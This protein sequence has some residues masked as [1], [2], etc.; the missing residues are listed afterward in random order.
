MHNSII[1]RDGLTDAGVPYDFGSADMLG[2]HNVISDWHS[3]E[4]EYVD[5]N[6]NQPLSRKNS[7]ILT[8]PNFANP[9]ENVANAN[10]WLRDMHPRASVRVVS[11]GNR[12]KY[13]ETVPF[14]ADTSS[15]VT[16]SMMVNGEKRKSIVQTV[17]RTLKKRPDSSD[18]EATTKWTK[19]WNDEEKDL[20]HEPRFTGLGLERGPYEVMAAIQRVLYVNSNLFDRASASGANWTNA[21]G[22]GQLQDAIDAAGVYSATNGN[23]RAY[24]FA[25]GNGLSLEPAVEVRDG[26]TVF[27]SVVDTYDEV[28][29]PTPVSDGREFLFKEK[30]IFNYINRVRASRSGVASS[31]QSATSLLSG[32][33]AVVDDNE[34]KQTKGFVLDGFHITNNA[35]Q[36]TE[37]PLL[38]HNDLTLLRNC[39]VRNNR[40]DE[41]VKS[42][43]PVVDIKGGLLYN[44]LV[45]DND[46]QT[47][48]N[49]V[50]E[51]TG[52]VLNCTVVANGADQIAI[53]TAT[54]GKVVNAITYNERNTTFLSRLPETPDNPAYPDYVN[55]NMHTNMFAPYLRNGANAYNYPFGTQQ[56][57][58]YQLH[59]QSQSIDGG[60]DDWAS[61][62]PAYT[63]RWEG[64]KGEAGD[65]GNEWI[66]NNTETTDD[67]TAQRFIDFSQDRDVLGNPRQVGSHVDQ[68]AF[69]TW[70]VDENGNIEVTNQT[71][72]E[73]ADGDGVA[74]SPIQ[75]YGGHYYPHLGSV[76]YIGK[77]ASLR[78]RRN[79]F[80]TSGT[81]MQPGYLLLKEGASLYGQGNYVRAAYVATEHT[82]AKD[83]T[84]GTEQYALF[85][86]PYTWNKANIVTTTYDSGTDALAQTGKSSVVTNTQRYD[87]TQRAEW[88]YA[89]HTADSPCWT[90]TDE[91]TANEGYLLTMSNNDLATGTGTM[92][93]FTAWGVNELGTQTDIYTED[94]TDK[95][96]ALQQHDEMPTD[97]KAHFTTTENMGWN[98]KGMPWLVNGFKTHAVD[99]NGDYDGSSEVYQMNVPHLFY[100]MDKTG[101]YIAAS[102]SWA[103]G[104]QLSYG[105]A[106]FT[107]TAILDEEE[108]LKFRTPYYYGAPV[109]PARPRLA[110]GTERGLDVLEVYPSVDE[111][112]KVRYHAGEDG[113]KW[114]T[115]NEAIP[116]FY[117][118]SDEEVGMSL[119][120]HAPLDTDIPLALYAGGDEPLYIWLPEAEA[121]EG[122]EGVWLKDHQTGSVVN[123][124]E[125]SYTLQPTEEGTDTRRLTL[126]LGGYVQR[127]ADDADQTYRVY[128]RAH[129]LHI[130]GLTEG[131][132][133]Q[134]YDPAGRLYRSVHATGYHYATDLNAGVYVV[135]IGQFVR[136]IRL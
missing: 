110:L 113:E 130:E 16:R 93:R 10:P 26:V 125:D 77:N 22:T 132:H 108:L 109:M 31:N 62:F 66:G 103:D 70:R 101:S 43:V 25:H 129:T 89:F 99:G 90:D 98:L 53:N 119:L 24:V 84:L 124:L 54:T 56:T 44:T 23:Q 76:V 94:G 75:H 128:G 69:E 50:S 80:L 4:M 73:D 59:E 13:E 118:L 55:S 11:Q 88:N 116:Q 81:A 20:A 87:G 114:L 41:S 133:I 61:Y 136:K 3:N 96:V 17:T 45:Y 38:L 49:V 39:V 134:V 32:V 104:S 57:L 9:M 37:S 46:A 1:W 29:S 71:D 15:V 67:Q 28:K 105:D 85:A 111:E 14:Y 107:Q 100:Q 95:T 120:A 92:L 82:F 19:M 21:F 18:E 72:T 36:L 34:E 30:E 60:T 33:R 48:V 63:N 68:G 35:T 115:F 79:N 131:D 27:G 106:Y 135:R 5:D 52:G 6:G 121:F 78:A 123:L 40:I 12:D 42:T 47:Q 74:D 122:L 64:L 7:D 112:K 117:A 2:M 58:W 97:G 126:R 127:E 102:Q 51:A 83:A 86:L 8:G 65:D 91:T